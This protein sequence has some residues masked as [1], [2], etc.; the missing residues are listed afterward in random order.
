MPNKPASNPKNIFPVIFINPIKYCPLI[1][2][3][4]VATAIVEKV[5]NDAKNPTIKNVWKIFDS[6]VNSNVV[7]QN[8][9]TKA[10]NILTTKIDT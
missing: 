3:W 7:I 2:S 10:P 4:S 1:K 5:V 9:A 8:P 6:T